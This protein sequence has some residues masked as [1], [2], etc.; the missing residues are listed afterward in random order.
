MALENIKIM[1]T[2]GGTG[3]HVFPAL[4][5][6][7]YFKSKGF[8]N[9]LYVGGYRGIENKLVP[10]QGIPYKKLWISGFAR[11][12][13]VKNLLFP[14]KLVVSTFQAIW[15]IISYRPHVIIGTGGYVEGPMVFVGSSLLFPTVICEQD[16]FPGI[17]TRILARYAKRIMLASEES[18][19]YF[20]EK[21][22]YKCKVAGNPVRPTLKQIEKSEAR[23]IFGLQTEKPVI[24]IIGG[25]LGAVAINDVILSLWEELQQLDIQIIWQTGNTDYERIIRELPETD[26]MPNV[27]PFYSNM[28]AVY[29]AADAVICRA[30]ALTLA[31]LKHMGLY[32]LLIP[33]P[34]AAGDHQ[35]KNALAMEEKGWA[36]VILQDDP[37]IK[38]KLKTF[39]KKV[40][41]NSEFLQQKS[42]EMKQQNQTDTLKVIYDSVVELIAKDV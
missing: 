2:G 26:K 16:V 36:E 30:G 22:H 6:I 20:P 28:N 42:E 24:A 27:Q 34:Y 15:N 14:L 3:G 12:N 39:L 25:S 29:S 18:I 31:E 7:E 32:S 4:A 41:E 13:L 5:I 23:K 21:L 40:K 17:T 9:F 35:K 33:Y 19:K 8:S 10:S 11:G 37:E 38:D 1:I